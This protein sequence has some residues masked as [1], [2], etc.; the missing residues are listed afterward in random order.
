[1]S[2]PRVIV[3]TPN[4]AGRDGVSRLARLVTRAFDTATVLALHEPAATT[5]FERAE[6]RG[7]DGRTSRFV[8]A[9]VRAAAA[10]DSHTIVVAVHLHLS[11]AALAFTARGAA[12]TTVLC[13]VEAW[14]PLTWMQRAAIDRT[15][16]LIAISAHTG[17]RFRTANPPFANRAIDICHLGVEDARGGGITG[18]RPPTALIVGRMA[19][20]E[21]YKG[22]DALLEIWPEVVRALPNAT[23]RIVGDG[24]D[25]PRL[26]DKAAE[27]GLNRTVAFLGR[28]DD[29]TLEREYDRCTAFVMPSKDEG[30]GFVFVEAM[31]AGRA[32]IASRGAAAEIVDDGVSGLVIDPADRGQLTG[33]VIRLLGDRA[34]ADR[35]GA[36]G[37][38]RFLRD[39]TEARFRERFTALVDVRVPALVE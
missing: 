15:E 19:S 35:M 10:A 31:R 20:D 16:H 33:S 34:G 22:H 3:L 26:E 39:F 21:R 14:K 28:V 13:G 18:D 17:D 38:A 36:R 8:A 5:S 30:F 37:R 6:V 29:Q 23:L 25:R 32:C 2:Q 4:L 27:L 12:L 7:G 24:D 9:A 1:V 11:P